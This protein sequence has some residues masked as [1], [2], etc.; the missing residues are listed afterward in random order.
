MLATLLLFVCGQ[1][2]SWR[3]S[4]S[5]SNCATLLL[6]IRPSSLHAAS[7]N[8]DTSLSLAV[9]IKAGAL[10]LFIRHRKNAVVPHL[11]TPLVSMLT[12][13]FLLTRPSLYMA[14]LLLFIWRPSFSLYGAPPSLYMTPLLL[15][16]WRP[17]F[18]LHVY[19]V[20]LKA[21]LYPT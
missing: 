9:S 2:H 21:F 8:A 3:P 4:S 14:P 16:I 5:W 6:F 15:F 19:G 12:P 1:Y 10:L 13:L 17:F 7:I 20:R 18:S 11:Y